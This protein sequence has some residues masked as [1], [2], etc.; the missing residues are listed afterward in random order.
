M[1]SADLS[2]VIFGHSDP[3]ARDMDLMLE[4]LEP[5]ESISSST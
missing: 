5:Q 2:R 1:K 3:I 4:M